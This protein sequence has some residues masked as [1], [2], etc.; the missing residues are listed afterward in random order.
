[1]NDKL[2]KNQEIKGQPQDV[3]KLHKEIGTL[4]TTLAKFVSGTNNLKKL[5]GYRRSPSDKFGNGYDG[6]I[7]VHNED[8]IVCY[9]CGK[10]GHMT[11]KCRDRP[12]NGATNT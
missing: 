6:E 10:I 11:S 1:M 7:Y 9:F 5:L 2:L 12:K 4:K 8:T 3:V